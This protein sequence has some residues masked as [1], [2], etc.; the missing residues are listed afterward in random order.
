MLTNSNKDEY[1]ALRI[2]KGNWNVEDARM[3]KLLPIRMLKGDRGEAYL[4]TVG[5]IEI[6]KH[7]WPGFVIE[8]ELLE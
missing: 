7:T 5:F 3:G 6:K 2:P 1:V 4:G 8:K